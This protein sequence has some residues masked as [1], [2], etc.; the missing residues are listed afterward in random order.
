M[1]DLSTAYPDRSLGLAELN[2]SIDDRTTPPLPPITQRYLL[3]IGV[4]CYQDSQGRRYVDQLWHKD[5]LEHLKYLKQ[6]VLASPCAFEEP[7]PGAMALDGDP[8]FAGVEFV[9]LPVATSYFQAILSLPATVRILWRAV[10]QAE[11]VHAG[12]AGSWIPLGWIVTP[13]ARWHHKF[14]LIIVESAFWRSHPG[15]PSK[16]HTR[17]KSWFYEQ[18]NRWCVNHA[19]LAIFTQKEY[20]DSLLTRNLERG[21]IIHA[22]WIDAN[23]IVTERK[24]NALWQEKSAP[25]QGKLQI[26]YVGRLDPAKGIQVLLQAMQVLSQQQVSVQ[27]DILGAG[28]L[29]DMC[30]QVSHQV[31]DPV[32][33]NIL[34]TVSYGS[35]LFQ[36]VQN[37]HA[38]VIPSISDE[39]PRI[40]YDAY[41][42]AVPVIASNT[43]GLRDCVESDV[44]GV[45]VPAGDEEALAAK[46]VWA[47]NNLAA[48]QK[49]GLAS[50]QF[51]YSLTHQEMHRR[52][53]QILLDRLGTQPDEACIKSSSVLS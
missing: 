8:A 45:L 32:A 21:H 2:S 25:A 29:L 47:R 44:T 26:L 3:T 17:L 53:W 37:Y 28:D 23:S 19:D 33:I 24:A 39:Q 16:P 1:P 11:V 6:L 27:L 31:S 9:D 36:L 46:L 4:E 20:Q 48:L 52:R 22:S 41:S 38:I 35:D 10:K 43:D 14:Y 42:Q 5:L 18:L 12:V 7:L 50:R 40:V 34:G 49:M 13:L 51:A 30:E 15:L